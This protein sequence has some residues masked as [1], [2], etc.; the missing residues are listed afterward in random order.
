MSTEINKNRIGFVIA[1]FKTPSVES[2]RFIVDSNSEIEVGELVGIDIN[3]HLIMAK[4]TNLWYYNP[5]YSDVDAIAFNLRDNK[6][7]TKESSFANNTFLL[8]ELQY[9]KKMTFG[10]KN[11]FTQVVYPPKPGTPVVKLVPELVKNAKDY[12]VDEGLDSQR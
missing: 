9:K 10:K 5:K 1:G 4:I 6:D 3:T 7:V 2:T 12:F 8:G 11:E